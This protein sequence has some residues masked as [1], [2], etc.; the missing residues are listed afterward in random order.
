MSGVQGHNDT[1][2][3]RDKPNVIASPDWADSRQVQLLRAHIPSSKK[4]SPSL[5]NLS[6]TLSAIRRLLRWRVTG[7]INRWTLG[8]TDL[9]FFPS[10]SI[11]R[12]I[13]YW[14]TGSLFSKAKSFLMLFALFGPNR[15]GICLSVRPIYQMSQVVGSWMNIY[16]FNFGFSLLDDGQVEDWEIVVDNAAA[17]WFSFSLS[18]AAGVVARMTFAQKK[19]DTAVDKNTWR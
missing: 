9:V 8:A 5:V 19:S 13:T 14:V 17:D 11:V 16:T 3:R 10:L 7:V 12:R 15:R 18:F 4:R 6:I 1:N 2:Q